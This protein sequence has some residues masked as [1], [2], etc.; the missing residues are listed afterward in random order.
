MN[1]L[2]SCKLFSLSII[3]YSFLVG[4]HKGYNLSKVSYCPNEIFK[5][6]EGKKKVEIITNK[7]SIY[8]E[9]DGKSAPLTS[10]N[11]L[12]LVSKGVYK[13][14]VFHKVINQPKPFFVQAGD[15]SL[16]TYS[17]KDGLIGD[18]IYI[19]PIKG[20]PRFIPLEITLINEQKPRYNKLIKKQS[21]SRVK[22]KHKKGSIAMARSQTLDS[23]SSQ[24]YISLRNSPELDGR[25]AVF[26]NTIDGNDVLELIEEGDYI[27]EINIIENNN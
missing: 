27:L 25:Y 13:D 8:F 20:Y 24:F 11:F 23:A 7:G 22:L 26:G 6:L 19:D 9:L 10:G 17:N 21:F 5:C 16:K 1:L 3:F 14:S 2:S 18:G 12:D 4:C 15:P